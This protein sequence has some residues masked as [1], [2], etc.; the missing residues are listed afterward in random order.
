MIYLELIL[1]L[2]EVQ[3]IGAG[4]V[5]T[6]YYRYLVPGFFLV[7]VRIFVTG[8]HFDSIYLSM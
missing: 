2:L 3:D 5:N 1:P 8:F 4:D 7:K 6:R